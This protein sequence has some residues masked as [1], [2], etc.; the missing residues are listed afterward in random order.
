M[1]FLYN[2]LV[3][4]SATDFPSS[5]VKKAVFVVIVLSSLSE[6]EVLDGLV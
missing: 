6:G 4:G 2:K 5:S 3:T 1:H